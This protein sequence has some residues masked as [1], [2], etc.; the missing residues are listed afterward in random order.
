LN[1]IVEIAPSRLNKIFL[2][3]AMSALFIWSPRPHLLADPSLN[4]PLTWR[5]FR[6]DRSL[7]IYETDRLA[8]TSGLGSLATDAPALPAKA[9]VSV[10]DELILKRA[11]VGEHI[12]AGLQIE[13]R[14]AA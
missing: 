13:R 12:P 9:A 4:G 14:R 5:D 2:Y 3:S 6:N 11:S 7:L 10:A 1:V 8:S